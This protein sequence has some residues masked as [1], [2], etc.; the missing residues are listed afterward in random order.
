MTCFFVVP[1]AISS[2]NAQYGA[3]TGAIALDF[4]WCI[5][6][7]ARLIDCFYSLDTTEDSH[8]NDVGV[9]CVPCKSVCS[10]FECGLKF[11]SK[12]EWYLF[13]GC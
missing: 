4:V 1:A 11:G 9:M 12:S 13:F 10:S 7:E 6:N 3:G 8:D 2:T 5:G